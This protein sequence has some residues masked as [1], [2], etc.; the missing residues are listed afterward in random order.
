MRNPKSGCSRCHRNVCRCP[1]ATGATGPVGATGASGVPGP[2]DGATGATGV[3]GIQGDAGDA[4][5]T[6]ATGADGLNGSV[7]NITALSAVPDAPLVEGALYYVETVRSYWRLAKTNT[8]APDAITIAVTQ[9]ATGRWLRELDVSDQSWL[10]VNN[11]YIDATNGNDEFDGQS[12]APGVAPAGPLKTHG[13]LARRWGE[14][15]IRPTQ[16]T[17]IG[18]NFYCAVN[19]LTSLPATDPVFPTCKIQNN[20]YLWYRG[21]AE[22]VLYSGSITALTLAAP[23]TNTPTMITDAAIVSWA[24]YVAKRLRITTAGARNN[25]VTWIAK[26]LGALQAR[27]STPSLSSQMGTSTSIP[28]SSGQTP[29]TLL[30]GDTFNI[31]EL[32]TISAGPIFVDINQGGPGASSTGRVVFGEINFRVNGFTPMSVSRSLW[33]YSCQIMSA[34]QLEAGFPVDN[35]L[36]NCLFAIGAYISDG[37]WQWNSGLFF[38]T[39]GS[40]TG[41]TAY[42]CI[43]ILADDVMFQNVGMRGTTIN[44]SSASV[45]DSVASTVNPG[46]H[47]VSIGRGPAIAGQRNGQRNTIGYAA[48]DVRLWGSG[49]AGTGVYVNAECALEYTS[50]V[51]AGLTVTGTGG[52]FR[53][54]NKTTANVWDQTANAGAGAFLAPRAT[55][56][57]NLAATVATTGFGGFA[58]DVESGARVTM[59]AA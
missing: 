56:W 11:W 41:L 14:N 53:L 25:T 30:V 29:Q 44:I 17:V 9:S 33:F 32:V 43:A 20:T 37:F 3:Q 38:G 13:E 35:V 57:A 21:R 50:G 10:I 6:G 19:I 48:V 16:T 4:G 45:F 42:N 40:S 1:G 36:N 27:V 24:P 31:E 28:A 34:I 7:P 39:V 46:G 59:A 55:T 5:A 22:T 2:A 58:Q 54:N 12:A 49:N 52:D 15:T 8:Q 18:T 47:G 23:A 51:V 26:D